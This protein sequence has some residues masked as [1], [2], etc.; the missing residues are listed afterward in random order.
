MS[1]NG[2]LLSLQ[3]RSTSGVTVGANYT[4]SHCIGDYGDVHGEGPESYDTYTDPANRA[5]DRG[6]CRGDRRHVFNLTPV[7]ETPQFANNTVRALAT[8]WK[9]SGIYRYS[10][11]VPLTILAGQDRALNGDARNQRADQVL[12]SGYGDRS[13]RPF[14]N[15]LNPAAFALAPA[16]KLGNMGRSNLQG[17]GSW[18]LDIALSRTFRVRERERLEFRGEAYN[19][20]NS[21]RPQDFTLGQSGSSQALNSNTFGQIR[22]ARDPRI[23]QFA[24]KFVF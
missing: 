5:F 4:W 9:L 22:T 18:Q 2:L 15:Y 8:G 3:R 21:F 1:Y 24:L 20:T 7:Y 10:S 6:D 12:E 23:M 11:G 16:G 17:P 13:G 14:T 19:V